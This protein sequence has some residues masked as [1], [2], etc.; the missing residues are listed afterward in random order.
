MNNN[1]NVSETETL[2]KIAKILVKKKLVKTISQLSESEALKLINELDVHQIEL[3]LQ[4]EELIRERLTS[5]A[6]AEKYIELYDFS[7]TG[8]FTLSKEGNILELNLSGSQILGKERHA[9]KNSRFAFFVSEDTKLIFNQFLETV[10]TKKTKVSCEVT[11]YANVKVPVYIHI[12]G[13]VGIN[14]E[15]CLL[16]VVDISERKIIEE[17]TKQLALIVQSSEDAIIGKNLEG[18]IT[19]WNN[20]AEK[21]YGYTENEMIGKSFSSLIS[22]EIN[23]EMPE[24][25]TMIRAGENIKHY[26]TTR[27]RKDGNEIHVSLAISPVRDIEGK[28]IGVSTIGRDITPLHTANEKLRILNK[29]LDQRVSQRT[30]L[31]EASNKELESFS[32]SVS[33]D[34]RAPLRAINSFSKILISEYENHLDEEGKRIC[35]I[36]SSSALKMGELVDD[37]LR[38]SRIGRSSLNHELL[39]MENI[40]SSSFA[41]MS[42]GNKKNNIKIKI[43]K[44]HK[45]SGDVHLIRLVWNNLISNAIKYSSKKPHSI[46]FIGSD[47]NDGNITYFIKDNGVGFDMQYKLKL[48]IVFQ[49]LHDE[50]EFEGNGV[51]LAI[52]QRIILKHGGKVWGEGEVGKGATFYFSLPVTR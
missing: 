23:E 24:I 6:A 26:E 9:L 50:T 32:Y 44:L 8:Y 11:L 43:G 16:S 10:F 45:V 30:A 7:P 33:H 37:L 36:I 13:V 28:I 21:L 39:D 15:Y 1:G 22:P 31:L 46:I 47:Q 4:K 48:F 25:I 38:F 35:G 49:R 18:I 40:A 51:G 52:A 19:S 12:S 5:K 3:E 42:K 34:L 14:D 29:E 41:E 2:H 20:G 17:K 27:I